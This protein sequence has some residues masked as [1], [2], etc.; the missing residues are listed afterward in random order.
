VCGW[1]ALSTTGMR[2]TM[3][4]PRPF[5]LFMSA[6]LANGCVGAFIVSRERAGTFTGESGD[7]A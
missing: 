2:S 1:P 4:S 5:G 6:P 3:G 7:A